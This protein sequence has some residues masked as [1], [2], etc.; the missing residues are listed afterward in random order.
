[1]EKKQTRPGRKLAAEKRRLARYQLSQF[2]CTDQYFALPGH[3]KAALRTL[4][5]EIK[6]MEDAMDKTFDFSNYYSFVQRR[7]N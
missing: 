5:P 7:S 3:I 4:C 1:M 6:K 2:A